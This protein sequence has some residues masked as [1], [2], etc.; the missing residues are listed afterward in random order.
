ME[1]SFDLV[2]LNGSPVDS[3]AGF[4]VLWCLWR[5]ALDERTAQT[6]AEQITSKFPMKKKMDS[7]QRANG[8]F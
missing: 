8:T 7:A 2:L 4:T 3:V 6:T 5:L 1:P